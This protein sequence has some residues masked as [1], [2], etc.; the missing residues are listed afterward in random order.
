MLHGVAHLGW[1]RVAITEIL[2]SQNATLQQLN[3]IVARIFVKF[4]TMTWN[5]GTVCHCFAEAV[6]AV[7][8]FRGTASAKQWHIKV[9]NSG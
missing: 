4:L 9:R 7:N 1:I 6:L 5:N 8:R 3:Q 2:A